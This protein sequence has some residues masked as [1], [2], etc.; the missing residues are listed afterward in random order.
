LKNFVFGGVEMCSE[1]G[2]SG[3]PVI[4]P[5]FDRIRIHPFVSPD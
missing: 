1:S 4:H 5:K 2:Q 3:Y